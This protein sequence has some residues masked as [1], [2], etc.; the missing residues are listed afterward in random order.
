DSG[1]NPQVG[2]ALD[3]VDVLVLGS[4]DNALN[5]WKRQRLQ[6]RHVMLNE[7][8]PAVAGYP[9]GGMQ[10]GRNL[11]DARGGISRPT[12]GADRLGNQRAHDFHREE[13]AEPAVVTV[14]PRADRQRVLH[15]DSR[16]ADLQAR[17]WHS[18]SPRF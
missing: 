15:L 4:S 8:V 9:D 5:D 17:R 7:I 13:L 18:R 10:P 14:G 16:D 6:D 1:E 12:V 11:V 3:D 2:A